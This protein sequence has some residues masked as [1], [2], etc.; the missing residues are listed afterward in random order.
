MQVH[1]LP[2]QSAVRHCP[3]N[4]TF[5]KYFC[6]MHKESDPAICTPRT[7]GLDWAMKH[8][9]GSCGCTGPFDPVLNTA[10]P[11]EKFV[12]ETTRTCKN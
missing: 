2:N 10:D 5:E 4:A 7:S 6:D 1:I 12:C 9:L 8:C 3:Q 11:R